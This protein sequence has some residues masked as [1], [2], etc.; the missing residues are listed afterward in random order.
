MDQF[1]LFL[2]GAPR[3]ERS[4]RLIEI[5]LHKAIGLL[6]YLAVTKQVY[7][8]DALATLFWPDSD[9]TSARASLRRTI[10]ALGKTI[11]A[12]VF[13][14]G[15]D[16]IGLD[17][18]VNLWIDLDIFQS[19]VRDCCSPDPSPDELSPECLARLAEATRLYS[20]EFLAGFTLRDSPAFDEW[21]FFQAE[22]LRAEFSGMLDRL[23]RWHS[24]KG[25]FEV[26]LDYCR[27]RLALDPLDERTHRELMRLYAHSGQRAA[28]SRSRGHAEVRV[29]ARFFPRPPRSAS[30]P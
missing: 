14:F 26:A 30:A 17:P 13:A 2:F 22:S 24:D 3:F 9:Q 19:L 12:G 21:Q 4:G 10:Y 5:S 15:A 25:E 8:R 16:T 28:N 27:R 23:V 7:S 11:G 20:D 29:P 1:K 18:Q 6:V